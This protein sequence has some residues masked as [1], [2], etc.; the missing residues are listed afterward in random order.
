VRNEGVHYGGDQP[1]GDSPPAR[2]RRPGY[3]VSNDESGERFAAPKRFA[4]YR[5]YDPLGR[6]IGKVEKLFVGTGIG[7]SV[8]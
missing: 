3:T 5:L 4:G 7:S 6:K 2:D 1:N 8:R